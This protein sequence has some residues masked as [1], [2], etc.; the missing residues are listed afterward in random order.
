M[1]HY[2]I[3]KGNIEFPLKIEKHIIGLIFTEMNNDD[4]FYQLDRSS[5]NRFERIDFEMGG[6]NG[7]DYD[8]LDKIKDRCIEL[9]CKEDLEITT[10]E[11]VESQGEGY[12]F[13][14]IVDWLREK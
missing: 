6:T 13:E 7:I 9:G 3:A 2:I 12:H 5:G 8:P 1:S 14:N 4:S 10:S 11:Y